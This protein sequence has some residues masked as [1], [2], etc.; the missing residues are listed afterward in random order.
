MTSKVLTLDVN[1][2]PSG[3]HGPF[4][5]CIPPHHRIHP[6]HGR[7][8][9]QAA[10]VKWLAGLIEIDSI[11][12]DSTVGE[13]RTDEEKEH[14]LRITLDD[15]IRFDL[16]VNLLSAH[17]S[18]SVPGESLST[19][20]LIFKEDG[21]VGCAFIKNILMAEAGRKGPLVV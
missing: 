2:V 20:G 5:A 9:V 6:G 19:G 14:F 7:R 11:R 12:F 10:P 1:A 3:L 13:L 17:A 21:A 16:P 4:P 18:S 15:S 8:G